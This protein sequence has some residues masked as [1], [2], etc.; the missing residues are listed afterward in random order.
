MI[1]DGELIENNQKVIDKFNAL[2]Q[3]V[4]ELCDILDGGDPTAYRKVEE[5]RGAVTEL[6]S[7]NA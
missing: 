2:S 6:R 1:I 5:L 4:D 7:T 3:M